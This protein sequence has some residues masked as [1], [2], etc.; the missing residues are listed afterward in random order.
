MCVCHRYQFCSFSLCHGQL[1]CCCIVQLYCYYYQP[2]T[3]G[4]CCACSQNFLSS[5]AIFVSVSKLAH[6]CLKCFQSRFCLL[7]NFSDAQGLNSN[8]SYYYYNYYSC[9]T[10]VFVAMFA[11]CLVSRNITR[12]QLTCRSPAVRD[13]LVRH[14][15]FQSSSTC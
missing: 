3:G 1:L 14:G 8:C 13:F 15:V 9:Y 7:T 12:T 5:L 10:D 2:T 4:Q 6:H 11:V